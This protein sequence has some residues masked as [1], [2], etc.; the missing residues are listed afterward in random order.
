MSREIETEVWKYSHAKASTLLVLLCIAN[1]A[2]NATREA[3]IPVIDLMDLTRLAERT[4]YLNLDKLVE[5]GEI[6]V[7]GD[8]HHTPS[9][10]IREYVVTTPGYLHGQQL[11]VY[12]EHDPQPGNIKDPERQ[13]A[14]HAQREYPTR[15]RRRK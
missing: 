12:A 3:I 9:Y 4:V 5:I 1:D 11:N 13:R 6:T 15:K 7:I 14:A 10:R 2:A 8:K